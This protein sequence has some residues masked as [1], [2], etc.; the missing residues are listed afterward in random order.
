[1]AKF[2]RRN[3]GDK[4]SLLKPKRFFGKKTERSDSVD[5]RNTLSKKEPEPKFE[6]LPEISFGPVNDSNLNASFATQETTPPVTPAKEGEEA[7]ISDTI[8]DLSA[9]IVPCLPSSPAAEHPSPAEKMITT[10]NNHQQDSSRGPL[11]QGGS[12]SFTDHRGASQFT[13]DTQETNQTMSTGFSISDMIDQACTL[14]WSKSS[15]D[16]TSRTA[17]RESLGPSWGVAPSGD[18]D[19]DDGQAG[20]MGGARSLDYTGPSIGET[21]PEGETL[22]T[23]AE[24]NLPPAAAEQEVKKSAN[25]E[26]RPDAYASEE[27]V[28][29]DEDEEDDESEEQEGYEL[30]LDASTEEYTPKKTKGKVWTRMK[31]SKT[32]VSTPAV[33]EDDKDEKY[34]AVFGADPEGSANQRTG[35]LFSKLSNNRSKTPGLKLTDEPRDEKDVYESSGQNP[36]MINLSEE[37]LNP[38]DLV[39][40]QGDLDAANP[41]LDEEAV[42]KFDVSDND[43]SSVPRSRSWNIAS[44]LKRSIS[45]DQSK[46]AV[47]DTGARDESPSLGL[48]NLLTSSPKKAEKPKPEASRPPKPVWKS[49]VDPNTGATYYYH[50]LTR[51]TTWTKPP[52]FDKQFLPKEIG[53]SG[54]MSAAQQKKKEEGVEV[55]ETGGNMKSILRTTSD[56][57]HR[58]YTKKQEHI[59]EL[60]L[61]MSPP[62]PAS[63]DKII[64]EYR[65]REDELIDQLNEIVES[66]PFDE[67]INKAENPGQNAIDGDTEMKKTGSFR[68]PLSY[69]SRSLKNRVMTASSNFTGRSNLTGRSN[70][71][72]NSRQTLKTGNTTAA[73]RNS[74][75]MYP[76]VSDITRSS[77]DHP[78]GSSDGR[79]PL[80]GKKFVTKGQSP[81]KVTKAGPHEPEMARGNPRLEEVAEVPT[82]VQVVK[83]P[84]NRELLVEEYSSSSRYGLR[85][86]KYS[87]KALHG[88]RRRPFREPREAHT[89]RQEPPEQEPTEEETS[90]L[91][92]DS[93]ATDSV[94]GLS[95][96]DA[97]FNTRKDEFDAAARSALDDAIRNR[98]WELAA[99]VTDEMR[100]ENHHASSISDDATPEEWT[101]SSLDK[102][103]SDNDW[104]A[105]ARYIASMRDTNAQTDPEVAHPPSNY[106]GGPARKRFGARSQL[107]HDLE[108]REI[109]QSSSWDSGTSFGSEFY[110][111]GSSAESPL[112]SPRRAPASDP[113]KN[114]AC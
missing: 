30:V 5:D 67:P 106:S 71:S 25:V 108:H 12:A 42:D 47:S 72:G 38:E 111:T 94:S 92:H 99:T 11:P 83:A 14:P 40:K 57:S 78:L 20:Q 6:N 3:K 110:S 4:K 60:L 46:R 105:V 32:R 55:P 23:E 10:I 64:D 1:M 9:S 63:V 61:D 2:F 84:R 29:G 52:D 24:K 41:S 66:Q 96:S 48:L 49:T 62:D 22:P 26:S 39:D 50:R 53:R 89:P 107:Q 28:G 87:G 70:V 113:R 68:L 21:I 85:A 18:D 43:V 13:G 65:G 109:D 79:P 34:R 75:R 100:G 93:F 82:P 8:S 101:Q 91:E 98:D 81:V 7:S 33:N 59:K 44:A 35:S 54:S 104:D 36:Q 56:S 90:A 17:D 37:V 31:M 76:V 74:G 15:V 27:E 16:D 73:A 114:F 69:K 51:Q 95:A 103:I 102:F 45:G 19:D 77:I 80:P 58:P 88:G 112:D 86:E 97:G